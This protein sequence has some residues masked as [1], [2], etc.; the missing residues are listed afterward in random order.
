MTPERK[1]QGPVLWLATRSLQFWVVMAGT[2]AGAGVGYRLGYVRPEQ[3]FETGAA[4]AARVKTAERRIPYV[5]TGCLAG[6]I[7]GSF[8]ERRFRRSVNR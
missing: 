8:C 7:A 3:E 5:A 4:A 2:L 1:R 6:A